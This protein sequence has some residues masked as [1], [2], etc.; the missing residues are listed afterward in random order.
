MI[1]GQPLSKAQLAL[2]LQTLCGKIGY[3]AGKADS[4][5]RVPG[6]I[7]LKIVGGP[8]LPNGG[9]E[10]RERRESLRSLLRDVASNEVESI[11]GVKYREAAIKIFR[12]D[13]K[14]PLEPSAH[15]KLGEI[16]DSLDKKFGQ[17]AGGREFY[18][19]H[20][21]HLLEVIAEALIQR[22][23]QAR[24]EEEQPDASTE[25]EE[26][27][28][29]PPQE[30]VKEGESDRESATTPRPD[31]RLTVGILAALLVLAVVAV[32]ALEV[33]G[34]SGSSKRQ[35][36]SSDAGDATAE[37]AFGAAQQSELFT[38]TCGVL[39]HPDPAERRQRLTVV[40]MD[41]AGRPIPQPPDERS[42][43]FSR[44]VQVRPFE[45]FQA[46]VLIQNAGPAIARNLRLRLTFPTRSA[47]AATITAAVEATNARPNEKFRTAGVVSLVSPSGEPFQLGNFRY[48]TAQRNERR[49]S[50]FWGRF[51][52]YEACALE[53]KQTAGAYEIAVPPPSTDG[54]LGVGLDD[55]YRVSVLAD[56]MPG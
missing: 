28:A 49:D 8:A 51:E 16:E 15:K 47:R 31:R 39:A 38:P 35:E 43:P 26:A 29:C 42:L 20:R 37:E 9:L 56:V 41:A 55:A 54:T 52:R 1:A 10:W 27:E 33:V 40:D 34:L 7:G 36:P 2:E 53:A 3:R 11:L 44:I 12:L 5:S 30:Q 46:S 22:E 50:L 13:K 24:Q 4:L 17:E 25:A 21:R 45:V 6:L 23:E 14:R 19:H 18:N 48:V 32:F